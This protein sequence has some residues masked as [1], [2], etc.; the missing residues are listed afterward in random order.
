[1]SEL[2]L[3]LREFYAWLA[4]LGMEPPEEGDN[5]RTAA[6]MA[7]FTNMSGKSLPKGKTVSADD[8]LGRKKEPLQSTDQQKA[9]LRSIT[10][11]K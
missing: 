9:F 11:N 10:G 1:M 3:S 4:Y 7:Q 8:F 6:L 2:R 5:A